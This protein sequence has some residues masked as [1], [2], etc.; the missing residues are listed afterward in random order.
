MVLLQVGKVHM[1]RHRGIPLQAVSFKDGTELIRVLD[2]EGALPLPFFRQY[3]KGHMKGL[4]EQHRQVLLQPGGL[5][6]DTH[7]PG[8]ERVA[9]Q[10]DAVGL[11]LSAA[12]AADILFAQLLLYCGGKAHCL[13]FSP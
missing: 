11:R 9:V 4:A 6:D 8:M 2:Q 1:E 5:G 13:S 12:A 7:P 3:V 10:Q